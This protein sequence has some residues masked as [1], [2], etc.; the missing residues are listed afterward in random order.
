MVCYG[1]KETFHMKGAPGKSSARDF[2]FKT[3][4]IIFF[5][6]SLCSPLSFAESAK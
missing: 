5:I 2:Y 1:V 3:I 6:C 4:A